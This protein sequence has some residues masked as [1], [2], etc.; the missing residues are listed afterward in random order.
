MPDSPPLF[1][2][3]DFR[4]TGLSDEEIKYKLLNEA[5][6]G[7]S[8]GSVFGS[9]GEGFQR[10]NLATPKNNVLK[11]LNRA[12]GGAEFSFILP[13]HKPDEGSEK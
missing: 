10:M 12:E 11:A 1:A 4:K 7:L 2:W 6:L 13:R 8:P 3:I 9:G 5:Q